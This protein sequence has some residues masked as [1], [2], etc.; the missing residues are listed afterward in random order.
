M[1]ETDEPGSQAQ[2]K[3]G[4]S[5]RPEI[6]PFTDL[7]NLP[8]L[9]PTSIACAGHGNGGMDAIHI[10]ASEF[11]PLPRRFVGTISTSPDQKPFCIAVEG[12]SMEDAK[13]PDRS[14]VV[15][16]PAEEVRTGNPALVCYGENG[17]WAVKWVYWKKDGGVE[18]RSAT[19]K[20][21]PREFTR[22]EIE[23]GFF[24]VIGKVVMFWGI[25]E[26]GA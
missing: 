25:P 14:V 19:L 4:T 2:K 1:G 20:Y 9:D 18:I 22:E 7:V 12:D 6:V 8:I 3:P 11:I 5:G 10:E 13:I 15:V 26:N 23:L 21:P 17:D 16:N 24:R